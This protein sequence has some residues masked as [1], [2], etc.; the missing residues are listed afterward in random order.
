MLISLVQVTVDFI[1]LIFMMMA[2]SQS[3]SV[4]KRGTDNKPYWTSVFF[5]QEI[6]VPLPDPLVRNPI[7]RQ[8]MLPSMITVMLWGN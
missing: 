8:C 3:I 7:S 2:A 4:I 6:R 5:T 1:I